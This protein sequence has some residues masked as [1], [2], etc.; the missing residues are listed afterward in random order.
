MSTCSR[1]FG[2][3]VFPLKPSKGR[4]R[5]TLRPKRSLTPGGTIRLLLATVQI[6]GDVAARRV[7]RWMDRLFKPNLE[8]ADWAKDDILSGFVSLPP[9]A[10]PGEPSCRVSGCRASHMSWRRSRWYALQVW[11]LRSCLRQRQTWNSMKRKI[12]TE[13]A[14]SQNS[15]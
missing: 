4:P 6:G 1:G 3:P 11:R 2:D 5:P 15:H 8:A 7:A 12:E 13:C 10:L 14:S 9:P